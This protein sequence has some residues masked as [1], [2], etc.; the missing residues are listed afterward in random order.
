VSLS[1]D[2]EILLDKSTPSY[3]K[4][5]KVFKELSLMQKYGYLVGLE[6]EE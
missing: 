3:E 6:Q 5:Y 2:F 4:S 1:K